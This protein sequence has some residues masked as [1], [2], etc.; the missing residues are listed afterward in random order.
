MCTVLGIIALAE[1]PSEE[2]LR[3]ANGLSSDLQ[4]RGQEWTGLAWSD[5]ELLRV[6]KRPGLVASLFEDV[7]FMEGLAADRPRMVLGHTRFS[8]AGDSSSRNAQPHFLRFRRGTVALASNGDV[9][10]YAAERARLRSLGSSFLSRNDG[11]LL[12]HHILA[13]SGDEPRSFPAGIA[14]CMANVRASYSA[15]LATRDTV[16]VFRDPHANRPLFTMRV[17]E[18][19]V[20]ASEDRALHGL[21]LQ[22]ANDGYHD[23]TVSIEQVMPGE[24]VQVTLEGGVQYLPSLP[25]ANLAHCAFERIYFARPDSHVFGS[26]DARTAYRV[27]VTRDGEGHNLE[28]L[29]P[30]V[31]EVGAFRYRLGRA[32]A[33]EHPAQAD[34]VIG[35]P[36]S[37]TLASVGYARESGLDHRVVLIRNPYISRTFISPGKTNRED[38]AR[39]K[40]RPMH[41]IFRKKPRVVVVDDSS[42]YGTSARAVV[43][44]LRTAGAKEVHFRASCPPIVRACRYGIDMDSKGALAAAPD[45]EIER[46]RQLLGVDTLGYLSLENLRSVIGTDAGSYC[47]A[48]WQREGWPI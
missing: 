28:V 18:Y 48:C 30:E 35:V 41:S 15:W 45:G 22:R 47:L 23:G 10:D 7:S 38:L 32:L 12:L 29:D 9:F 44:M 31:E 11:E 6:E 42:V 1:V 25:S 2:I 19:F 27:N 36:D 14:D 24:I 46:V 34:F 26:E 21:L 17:G 33:L 20:F 40:Y 43:A 8:T 3:Y 5:G 16:Y 4:H 37:G 39:R 13:A